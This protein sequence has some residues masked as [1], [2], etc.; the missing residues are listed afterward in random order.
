MGGLFNFKP[1]RDAAEWSFSTAPLSCVRSPGVLGQKPR[2]RISMTV[3]H[4]RV[5]PTA[6]AAHME[7]A[8]SARMSMNFEPDAIP[9]S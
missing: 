4:E 1:S 7:E 3:F 8:H 6:L 5:R 2:Q 9:L